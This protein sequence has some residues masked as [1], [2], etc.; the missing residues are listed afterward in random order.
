MTDQPPRS[1][2]VELPVQL[3]RDRITQQA[4]DATIRLEQLK[5][6]YH[7]NPEMKLERDRA[8][9]QELQSD[10][11]HLNK[12]VGGSNAA[13]DEEQ[14]LRSNIA[15]AESKLEAERLDA[16]K[17]G[18]KI[19]L[20]ALIETTTDGQLPMREM[21]T[22]VTDLRD[23]GLND[24]CIDEA[25]N[26]SRNPPAIIAEA[27]ERLAARLSDPEWVRKL[28]AGDRATRKELTLLHIVLAS[29]PTE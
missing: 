9:L 29:T 11:F 20:P 17:R 6:E 26:G 16:A 5:D 25:L 27:K 13:R 24:V 3:D 10:P 12:L 18:E 1:N 15:I 28:N 21:L 2:M 4:A 19:D 8:R 7:N 22:A 23:L 14:A